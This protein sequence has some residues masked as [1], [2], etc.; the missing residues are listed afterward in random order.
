MVG[1]IAANLVG[2]MVFYWVDKKI[3]RE[4]IIE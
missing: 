3:F 4:G 1:T 2:G